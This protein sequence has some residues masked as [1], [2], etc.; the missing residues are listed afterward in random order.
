MTQSV[1]GAKLEFSYGNRDN[2]EMIDDLGLTIAKIAERV[3]GGVLIFFPSYWLMDKLY[4][5]W[6]DKGILNFIYK[7]KTVYREPKRAAEYQLTMDR[8]YSDVFENKDV[9]GSILMG[10]CRGRISEG[11]DFSDK[12]ARMV[13]VVGI[14]FPMMTDPK[15]ILKKEY[16]DSKKSEM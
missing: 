2:M 16:L 14:P 13:I 8:Y 9:T 7:H 15:V 12:A 4:D 5:R 1:H 6:A 11:L 10:V 3:P